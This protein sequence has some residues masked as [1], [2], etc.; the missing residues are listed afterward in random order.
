MTPSRRT[1]R[2]EDTE[3]DDR[4]PGFSASAQANGIRSSLSMPIG[5]SNQDTRLRCTKTG[6]EALRPVGPAI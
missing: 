2:I 5:V 4:W 1:L 6:R 3:T